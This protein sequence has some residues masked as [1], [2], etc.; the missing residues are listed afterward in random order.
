MSYKT[1][2]VNSTA[3]DSSNNISID[4]TNLLDAG[5]S[6]VNCVLRKTATGWGSNSCL[7]AYSG[8]LNFNEDSHAGNTAYRYDVGD[9]YISRYAG[10]EYNLQDSITFINS[11]GS[12][13]PIGSSSW[14][15]GYTFSGSAFSGKT[16]ILRAVIAGKHMTTPVDYDF[17]WR[18]G[19]PS[20][21]LNTTTALGPLA[22]CLTEY[23]SV[24]Y[25]IFTGSGS[26]QTVSIRF[27]NKTS[28]SIAITSGAIA[29]IQ[30][31]TAKIIE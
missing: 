11:S 27:I 4:S 21:A 7:K 2:K 16:V 28:G 3:P 15:M 12:Y 14:V 5:R 8:H 23:S 24:A 31:I 19:S 10:G 6:A 30:S 20:N 29:S 1:L 9:N 17:Q 26:D 13:V 18:L 25:G 22:K